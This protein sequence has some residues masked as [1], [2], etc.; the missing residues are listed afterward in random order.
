M[1]ASLHLPK[2]LL[3]RENIYS[4][5]TD[6]LIAVARSARVGHGSD[7]D[8]MLGPVQSHL[9]YQRLK[10]AWEEITKSRA[11]RGRLSSRFSITISPRLGR[12]DR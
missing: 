4:A 2:R 5:V 7:P 3:I 6:A 11:I 8:T 1:R 10:S 12:P 9:Q